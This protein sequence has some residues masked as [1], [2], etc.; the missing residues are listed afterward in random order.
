MQNRNV[1]T[2]RTI[3]CRVVGVTFEG[4][5]S[6]IEEMIAGQQIMLKPEPENEFDQNAIAVYC[7]YPEHPDFVPEK[8]GYIP[9]DRAKEIGSKIKKDGVLGTVD[10]ITGGFKT[11]A[12]EKAAFG[13]VVR[14]Q[15]AL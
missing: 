13:V 7:C 14:F 4:R 3:Y 10:E 2:F 11:S 8:I 15:V 5:Q 12:G 6:I 9:R 1:E